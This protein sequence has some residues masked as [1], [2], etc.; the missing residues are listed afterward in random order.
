MSS[1]RTSFIVLLSMSILPLAGCSAHQKPQETRPFYQKELATETHGKKTLFDRIV[2]VDPGGLDVE[3]AS[4]YEKRPPATIAVLPFT[5]NGSAQYTVDK[6]PLSFR[7][8]QERD[9][10]T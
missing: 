8:K 7:N 10:W 2:E 6:I 9:E 4:D 1:Q 3:M 5:D